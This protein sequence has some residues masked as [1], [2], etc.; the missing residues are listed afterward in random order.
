GN[1]YRYVRTAPRSA[2]RVASVGP[3]SVAI[4]SSGISDT[5]ALEE[6]PARPPVSAAPVH[7]RTRS[8]R[9]RSNLGVFAVGVVFGLLFSALEPKLA[10]L[11]PLKRWWQLQFLSLSPVQRPTGKVT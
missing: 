1:A 6:V 4:A 9:F 3:P 5:K 8:G 7:S 10:Q 2:A 11:V